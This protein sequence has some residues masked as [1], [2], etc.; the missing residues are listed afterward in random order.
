MQAMTV[1]LIYL[2]LNNLGR[3]EFLTIDRVSALGYCEAL[4]RDVAAAY[5]A[6]PG[7]FKII[8]VDDHRSEI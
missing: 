8:C 7:N 5:K 4:E 6:L 3:W 2:M 1:L